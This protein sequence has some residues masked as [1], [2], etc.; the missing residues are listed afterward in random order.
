MSSLISPYPVLSKLD[1]LKAAL[2]K[3]RHDTGTIGAEVSE[4]AVPRIDEGEVLV[5]MKA[6]GLC[7]T[8]LEKIRGEYTS[9]MPIIGHEAVGVISSVGEAVPDLK[10]GDRVF[11]HHHVPC[12]ECYLCLRGKETMCPEYKTSNLEPGGFSEYIRVPLWNVSKGGVS[13]LPVRLPFDEGSLIEPL[14]CCVRA[15]DRCK[16]RSGDAALVVGA[17]P[18]GMM[19]A[20]LLRTMNARVYVSD[21]AEPRLGFAEEA[22]V[23]T[24]LDAGKRNVPEVVKVETGGRGADLVIVAT[25]SQRAVVQA[26]MSVRMGGTICLFGIP[27]EGS[28]IDL[29]LSMVYSSAVTIM[30]SYGADETDVSKAIKLLSGRR[31]DLRPLITHHFALAEFEKGVRAMASGEAMKVVITP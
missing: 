5:E 31:P 25:G 2:L 10:V 3:R 12:H 4:V 23:G 8:D 21:V 19:H 26:L 11:P 15:L 22:S 28:A 17:G 6:C 14:A 18:I 30:S 9:A 27:P 20:F 7:G 29:D 16:A 24:V 1:S 13:P